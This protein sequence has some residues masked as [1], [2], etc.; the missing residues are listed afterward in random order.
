MAVIELIQ[1]LVCK[2]VMPYPWLN[3]IPHR[4]LSY[5]ISLRFYSEIHTKDRIEHHT[6]KTK[7]TTSLAIR[8]ES[9]SVM[10]QIHIKRHQMNHFKID[11]NSNSSGLHYKI[12]IQSCVCAL[13]SRIFDYFVIQTFCFKCQFRH[14]T[15]LFWI[16]P[17]TS[18][19]R[20]NEKLKKFYIS[21]WSQWSPMKFIWFW[22]T[23]YANQKSTT[24]ASA[25]R[26][27]NKFAAF[28]FV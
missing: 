1:L 8:S 13:P 6:T 17:K 21:I 7:Q 2:G 24:V 22:M 25:I 19:T 5:R 27:T 20:P 12:T 9:I 15:T 26:T 4:L 16:P 18:P 10:F 3:I 11:L 23:I 14:S 28:T